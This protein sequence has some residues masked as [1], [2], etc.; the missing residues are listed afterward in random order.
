MRILKQW[1]WYWSWPAKGGLL[2]GRLAS[3]T[4]LLEWNI[5]Q[6][7]R[8]WS[9]CSVET[10]SLVVFIVTSALQKATLSASSL[11]FASVNFFLAFSALVLVCCILWKSSKLPAMIGIGRERTSTPEFSSLMQWKKN[12]VSSLF[13]ACFEKKG[14]IT[15]SNLPQSRQITSRFWP[16][17]TTTV[18]IVMTRSIVWD[19]LCFFRFFFVRC[20]SVVEGLREPVFNRFVS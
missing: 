9:I 10:L 8:F 17:E 18:W 19:T 14:T 4:S 11:A 1:W 7:C 12:Y 13:V 2:W 16:F 15:S 5:S 6:S 3:L 20:F